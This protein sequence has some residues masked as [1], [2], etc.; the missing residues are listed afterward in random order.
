MEAKKQTMTITLTKHEY[1]IVKATL[2]CMFS[3]GLMISGT[4]MV[5]ES[6]FVL[7]LLPEYMSMSVF[8]AVAF[9]L[10]VLLFIGLALWIIAVV[11]WRLIKVE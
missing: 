9:P 6:I 2:V 11:I 10:V 4:I 7:T 1:D 8:M 5:F 3:I